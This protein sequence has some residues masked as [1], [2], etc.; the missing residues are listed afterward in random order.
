VFLPVAWGQRELRAAPAACLWGSAV[1][2]LAL[3]GLL[4]PT[5]Y[6]Y[7][8]ASLMLGV[9]LFAL[10]VSRYVSGGAPGMLRGAAWAAITLCVLIG[11]RDEVRHLRTWATIPSDQTSAAAERRLRELV[12]AGDLVA[13]TPRHW[14]VFQG[15]NPWRDAFLSTRRT[16]DE[17]RRCRWLVLYPGVGDPP[18]LEH[19]ELVERSSVSPAADHTYAYSLWRRRDTE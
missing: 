10:V 12:P 11:G 19:F 14:H 2:S 1:G 17:I 4:R 7:S 13:V 15:R 9:P 3:V 5:A 8:G 16:D 18:Y 6:T